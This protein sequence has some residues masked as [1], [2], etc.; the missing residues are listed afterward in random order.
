MLPF[1]A[2]KKE[3]YWLRSKVHCGGQYQQHRVERTQNRQRFKVSR[4][5][6]ISM[7]KKLSNYVQIKQINPSR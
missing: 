7:L 3:M 6:V 1:H 5:K 2:L 4:K